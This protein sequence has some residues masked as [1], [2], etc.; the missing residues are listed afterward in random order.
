MKQSIG[1][2]RSNPSAR[3]RGNNRLLREACHPAA[4][5]ADRVARND[6]ETYGLR[7]AAPV[8]A[9]LSRSICAFAAS[10]SA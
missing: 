6:G 1:K 2:R 7:I 4:L 9:R 5:C 3:I 10:F 8:V